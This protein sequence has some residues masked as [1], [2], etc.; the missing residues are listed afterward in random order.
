MNVASID[1][2][3]AFDKPDVALVV[4]AAKERVVFVVVFIVVVVLV[5][6][7]GLIVVAGVEAAIKGLPY[8][9]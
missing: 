3:Q 7:I 8:N 2:V 1:L 6:L 9:S 5:E 4:V